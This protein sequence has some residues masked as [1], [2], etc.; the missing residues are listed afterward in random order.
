[1]TPLRTPL[2]VCAVEPQLR[3]IIVDLRMR[4]G[5]LALQQ[6]LV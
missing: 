1:M 3:K 2:Q 4:N 5:V 6:V